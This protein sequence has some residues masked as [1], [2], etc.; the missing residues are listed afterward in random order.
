MKHLLTKAHAFR[1]T[2]T[3]KGTEL[4]WNRL[5]HELKDEIIKCRQTSSQQ[6]FNVMKSLIFHNMPNCQNEHAQGD[7]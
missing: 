5:V 2:C 4:F 7:L 1:G 3:P 6:L